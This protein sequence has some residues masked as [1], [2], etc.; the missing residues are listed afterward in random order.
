MTTIN[1]RIDESTKKKFVKIC[2]D[3]GLDVS[4]L[5]KLFI[6]QVIYEQRIP[7]EI[8]TSKFKHNKD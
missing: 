1:I 3:M 5:V 2:E 6:M 4:S 7:F 8:K